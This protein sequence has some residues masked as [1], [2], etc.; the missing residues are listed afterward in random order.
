VQD[1]TAKTTVKSSLLTPVWVTSSNMQATVV[2]DGAVTV[3]NLC[4]SAVKAACTA[5]GIS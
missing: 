3:S 1:T 4:T 5:A 2:K